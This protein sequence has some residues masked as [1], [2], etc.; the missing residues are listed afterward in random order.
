MALPLLEGRLYDLVT[1]SASGSLSNSQRPGDDTLAPY[2]RQMLETTIDPI[3][4]VLRLIGYDPDP[5]N[6]DP[7]PSRRRR[8]PARH[9]TTL[10]DILHAGLLGA[11][12]RLVSTNNGHPADAVLNADGS[13]TWDG[14]V[15]QTPSAAG[16]AVRGGKATNGW[17]FWA[18]ETDSG[19]VSLA[20][21]R[22]RVGGGG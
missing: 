6:D 15:Y 13:I 18:I 1:A 17:A 14:T 19:K 21:L 7:E 3:R 12:V 5:P 22:S 16:A 2:D 4:R 10:A 20:T 11:G 9:A 8:T